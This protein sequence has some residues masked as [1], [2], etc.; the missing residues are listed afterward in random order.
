MLGLKSNKQSLQDL[1]RM[2]GDLVWHG[3]GGCQSE[4]PCISFEMRHPFRRLLVAGVGTAMLQ[5][6]W[7][8]ERPRH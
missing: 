4:T 7:G 8:Q 1:A 6:H 3:N 2:A 5:E